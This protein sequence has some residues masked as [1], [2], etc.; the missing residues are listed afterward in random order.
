MVNGK[1]RV[2]VTCSKRPLQKI[3]KT[4]AAIGFEWFGPKHKALP[5]I[6]GDMKRSGVA[7]YIDEDC[8][9]YTFTPLDN[10]EAQEDAAH[11]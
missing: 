5:Q 6:L 11:N 1:C 8:T 3:T 9:V 2:E 7:V 4:W 10:I